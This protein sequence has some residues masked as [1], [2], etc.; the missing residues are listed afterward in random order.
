MEPSQQSKVVTLV[1]GQKYYVELQHKE[2]EGGGNS[3]VSLAWQ[4]PGGQ[5]ALIPA[6]HLHS[7]IRHS[8]DQDD[9][10]LPDDWEVAN[11][12][13]P[14][15]NGSINPANGY[16]G[17]LDGDGLA[18]H[19]EY[20]AGTRADLVDTDGDGVSDFDEV[21]TLETNAMAGDVAPF[22]NVQT[23]NG[24]AFVASFG[25]WYQDGSMAYNASTRGWVEYEINVP[26]SGVYLL[27]L[28]LGSRIGGELSDEYE[29]IFSMGGQFLKRVVS[30][31]AVGETGDAKVVTPWLASGTQTIRVFLDNALTN[32]RVNFIS[33]SLL[34]AQGGDANSNGTPD[35]VEARLEKHNGIDTR[36]TTSQVSPVCVEGRA[37]YP[38]LMNVS[39]GVSVSPSASE[40][41]VGNLDLNPQSPVTLHMTFEN[42][43]LVKNQQIKWVETNLLAETNITLRVGDSMLLTAFNGQSG[44]GSENVSLTIEGQIHTFSAND[45]LQYQF[46]N[47]GTHTVNVTW[48]KGNQ[49]VQ[50]T[51]AVTVAEPVTLQ[52]PVCVPGH[53]REWD[54]PAL[55]A[56]AIV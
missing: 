25:E 13:D 31:I 45:P 27:D 16:Y 3:P 15:D 12:L 37:R 35:W 40:R 44:S 50:H 22:Q 24:G 19:E 48:S 7:Y 38:E 56:G 18:N 32:R 11:G 8:N 41:W 53:V 54:V 17:D 20:A 29:V 47:A 26:S 10:D 9:D 21:K 5:R 23:I 28:E 46:N 36:K 2:N 39:D 14:N 51:V 52:H 55:P 49:N 42:G 34:S 43:G 1:A 33:L 6:E 30:N 4:P